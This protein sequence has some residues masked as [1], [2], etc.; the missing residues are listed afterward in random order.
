[1]WT[2]QL[3]VQCGLVGSR[4][5]GWDKQNGVKKV[6]S[7]FLKM[8]PPHKT[9]LPIHPLLAASTTHSYRG[10]GFNSPRSRS[11]SRCSSSL[12]PYF[13]PVHPALTQPT[14]LLSPTP[15]SATQF[16][17]SGIYPPHLTS[18]H[19]TLRK[20]GM[21]FSLKRAFH[22]DH[23]SLTPIKERRECLCERR[24]EEG[25]SVRGLFCPPRTLRVTHSQYTDQRL[26]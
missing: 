11:E 25:L 12:Q 10:L 4:G 2:S 7:K 13:I 14:P 21:S 15:T 18:G 17:R 26:G 16:D 5:F 20:N 1:M 9:H 23:F 22:A 19:R 3:C 6:K 24:P 8:S